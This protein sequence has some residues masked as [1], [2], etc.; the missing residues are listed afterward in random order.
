ME[1]YF[2]PG[3]A[4]TQETCHKA[5]MGNVFDTIAV[6]AEKIFPLQAEEREFA[7]MYALCVLAPGKFC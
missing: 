2:I 3:T 4:Y 7:L 6:M 5:G 1:S